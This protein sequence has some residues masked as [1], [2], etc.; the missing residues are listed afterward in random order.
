MATNSNPVPYVASN[1]SQG[2]QESGTKIRTGLV[3]LFSGEAQRVIER[4]FG[5]PTATVGSDTTSALGH[6]AVTETYDD[7]WAVIPYDVDDSPAVNLTTTVPTYMKGLEIYNQG[8]DT[9]YVA[10]DNTVTSSGATQGR[11][12]PSGGALALPIGQRLTAYAICDTGDTAR[13]FVSTFA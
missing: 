4:F 10:E 6:L 11:P 7:S 5:G 8:P 1:T 3:K 13:V 9:I 12:V 2:A